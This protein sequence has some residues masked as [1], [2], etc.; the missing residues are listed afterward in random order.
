MSYDTYVY[1]NKT[2]HRQTLTINDMNR[3]LLTWTNDSIDEKLTPTREATFIAAMFAFIFIFIGLV[4]NIILLAT[5]LSVKKL[6]SNIINIFIVS[7][8]VNDLMNIG[9]NQFFV[10]LSYANREWLGGRILC[11][12]VVYFSGFCMGCL[13]WH[14][15]LIAIHRYVAVVYHKLLR[16]MSLKTYATVSLI[17]TRLVPIAACIPSFR[18]YTISY[19]PQILRCQFIGRLQIIINVF[20]LILLPASI[21]IFC[22]LGIFIFVA[23]ATHVSRMK[24]VR[25]MQT[26]NT[27]TL[28]REIR[29]T[30]MFGSLFAIFLFGYLPYGLVRAYDKR[31]HLHPD[32]Y[33][34]LT[35]IYCVSI[36]TSPF[37]Y[38]IMNN[39]LRHE[40]KQLILCCLYC[41]KMSEYKKYSLTRVTAVNN[42]A[43]NNNSPSTTSLRDIKVKLKNNITPV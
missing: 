37:V 6:R 27:Q 12:L 13:L 15:C 5:I 1:Y 11:D 43:N 21:I 30:K 18:R 32:I 35:I 8:Q 4:G 17:I 26:S 16:K 22:F 40:C 41:K 42:S 3:S 34:L 23:R 36:C 19:S 25:S 31:G 10:G 39:Q 24:Q 29:I 20:I 2:Q 7:L 9:F 14:H 28:R 33:V 38:G